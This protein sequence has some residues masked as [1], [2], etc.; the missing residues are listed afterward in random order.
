[1]GAFA[2]ALQDHAYDIFPGDNQIGQPFQILS[3]QS[4]MMSTEHR[5]INVWACW[6]AYS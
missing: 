1:M 4:P 2:K 3:P 6:F 5:F